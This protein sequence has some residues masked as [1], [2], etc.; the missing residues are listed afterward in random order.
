MSKVTIKDIATELNV[1]TTTV[2]NALNEKPGVGKAARKEI[3]NLAKK[4]GY[5]P[6]YFARGLVSQQ[7]YV[8]GMTI[9]NISDPFSAQMAR[10]VFDK[11]EEL[12]YTVMLLNTSYDITNETKCIEILNAK[13]VDGILMS[14]VTQDDPNI[15]LLNEMRI[16]YV[17]V[18]R[19]ILDPKKGNRID[20]VSTDMQSGFYEAARH[21]C[22]L[23]HTN[24]AMILGDMKASTGILL[25]NGAM[26][27][28]KEY[29]ITI[30][31][32]KLVEC[33]FSRQKAYESAKTI[34]SGKRR[35]SAILVQG[36]S[37]ALGVREAAC[38]ANLKIPEDLALVGYDDIS[39]ASLSG[40][41]LT[42][43]YQ[44]T[45]A[46]GATGIGLLIDKIKSKDT[47]GISSKIMMET[48]LV[49]R[50]TCGFHL[51]GYIK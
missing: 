51:K 23:G 5:Q 40:I 2:H 49:V 26:D 15:D 13:G 47:S 46:M 35:P 19:L 6:N 16:P 12:G 14:T 39:V 32:D 42:T 17:L 8:I 45:Y 36:D 24:I 20:S 7:S 33:G 43:V 30:P 38:E 29:G 31:P 37:M 3:I 50:K 9:S 1:S 34:L 10:G 4:M 11:A 27:A 25:K 28:F 22:R 21:I 18:N 44:D 48:K 41:E